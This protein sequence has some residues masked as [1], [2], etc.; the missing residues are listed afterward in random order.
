M[1]ETAG[2][3]RGVGRQQVEGG[4]QQAGEGG[5]G[6]SRLREGVTEGDSRAEGGGRQQAEGGCGGVGETAGCGG[7]WGRQQAVE[8]GGETAG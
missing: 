1:G 3:G 8:G 7:G 6:D 5:G 4:R 2:C